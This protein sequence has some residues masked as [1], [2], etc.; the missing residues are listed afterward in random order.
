V[1][2]RELA[3]ELLALTNR[4]RT[5]VR[6]LAWSD[7]LALVARAH[8]A[9]L[10]ARGRIAHLDPKGF[11]ATHRLNL[12]A[13]RFVGSASENV[14]ARSGPPP[15]AAEVIDL[16]RRSPSH[17]ENLRRSTQVAAGFGA[18]RVKDDTVVV[19]L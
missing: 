18:V 7:E 16:W 14:A 3:R 15:S 4:E 9:D 12:L 17:W 8:A 10:A 11:D 6:P 13:R 1:F 2:Q 19:A 5:G